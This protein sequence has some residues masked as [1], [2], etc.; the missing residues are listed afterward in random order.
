M[1]S[2]LKWLSIGSAA[3]LFAA[4]SVAVVAAQTPSDG[5]QGRPMYD[6]KTE[7]T[8]AGSVES[9][10]NVAGTAARGP[11]GLGGTHLVVKSDKD[12]FAV[13]VG[14]TAYLAEKK[15]TLAKGDKVEILGSR[16]TIDG[17]TVLIARQIRKGD[18]TWTLRDASGRPAWSGRGR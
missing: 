10:E 2:A 7:M 16:V 18:E 11:N 13:H 3:A 15:I 12:S 5:R 9:V 4:G 6:P 17:K 14:P 1:K 8:I